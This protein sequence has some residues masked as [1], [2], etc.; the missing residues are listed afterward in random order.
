MTPQNHYKV[1]NIP[2]ITKIPDDMWDTITTILPDKKPGNTIGRPAT[3]FRRVMN[4]I[5]CVLRTGASGS[6]CQ[7]NSFPVPHA[8]EGSSS[9]FGWTLKKMWTEL[10]GIYDGK[11]EIR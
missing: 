7:E 1:K 3:P 4:G 2:V 9:G 6:C 8:T 11:K 10:L 5:A